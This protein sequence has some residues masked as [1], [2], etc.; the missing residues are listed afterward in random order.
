MRDGFG[1]F[2]TALTQGERAVSQYLTGITTPN[3]PT[4]VPLLLGE[5]ELMTNTYECEIL[6]AFVGNAGGAGFLG[7][8][9]DGWEPS[10]AADP[11]APASQFM[12]IPGGTSGTPVWTSI[13]GGV[14]SSPAVGG[15]PSTNFVALPVPTMDAAFEA[16]TRA[17]LTKIIVEV[18]SDAPAQTAQGTL[19]MAVCQTSEAFQDAL[20]NGTN[21]AS[22]SVL[23]Q[24]FV[25]HEEF[26][27]ANWPTGKVL[28][29]NIVPWD[30]QCF[31]MNLL[32]ASGNQLAPR[33]GIAVLGAGMTVG[34]SVRFRVTFGYETTMPRT[35][36][37]NVLTEATV[38]GSLADIVAPIKAMRPTQV[39]LGP[40]G[41]SKIKGLQAIAAAKPALMTK[42]LALAKEPAR[43]GVVDTLKN[44]AQDALAA[45]PSL[46]SSGISWLSKRF[47]GF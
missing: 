7:I 18:W 27:L 41:H 3:L 24:N 39:S 36:Q 10:G 33:F 23:P 47:L 42:I 16:T 45:A 4:R 29:T 5:F 15:I 20:L 22:V 31:E 17:R 28:A 25:R 1:T 35:Y 34:Q 8:G 43:P 46:I 2:A 30:A 6:G 19:T 26:P 32:T 37:T 13:I 14:S 21:Y 44:F 40:S 9:V 11:G 12:C 38:A